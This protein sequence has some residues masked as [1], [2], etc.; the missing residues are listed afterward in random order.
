MPSSIDYFHAWIRRKHVGR[1]QN[2]QSHIFIMNSNGAV[3]R[4][5][6]QKCLFL[7]VLLLEYL[8]QNDNKMIYEITSKPL[9]TSRHLQNPS[10]A[11]V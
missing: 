1:K 6:K 11:Q 7:A 4:R 5:R 8:K 10:Q 9:P 2:E 3:F